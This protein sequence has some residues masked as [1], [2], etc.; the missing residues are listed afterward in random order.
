MAWLI[1]QTV[2]I[3]R[4]DRAGDKQQAIRPLAYPG[5]ENAHRWEVKVLDNGIPVSIAGYSVSAEFD[6]QDGSRAASVTSGVTENVAWVLFP[7]DVYNIEGMVNARMSIS[8]SGETATIAAISFRVSH[9]NNGPIIDPHGAITMDVA[10]LIADIEDATASIPADY[11][12]LL[13]TIAKNYTDLTFPISA[14]TF[15]WYDGEL[16]QAIDDIPLAE[17][18]TASHW[19]DG[20]LGP[21]IN[22]AL[23]RRASKQI[24]GST[25][26]KDLNHYLDFPGW[27]G[28]SYDASGSLVHGPADLPANAS[29]AVINF[30]NAM[31]Y[32]A[33]IQYMI[34]ELASWQRIIYVDSGA[35]AM[36][37]TRTVDRTDI[38]GIFNIMWQY[39]RPLSKNVLRDLN[40][41]AGISSGVTCVDNGDESYTLTGTNTG[42]DFAYF[43]FGAITSI[44]DLFDAG[45]SYR[46]SIDAD[47][48]YFGFTWYDS[49]QS[50]YTHAM[51]THGFIMTV[52][53]NT[54]YVSMYLAVP[55]GKTVN[56]TVHPKLYVPIGE[57]TGAVRFDVAQ[58]LTDA[59]RE[60]AR[61]NI[62]L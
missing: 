24:S 16:Y 38:D 3:A 53:Q 9:R 2:D 45:A 56:R 51:Y 33:T 52:P 47:D 18:W 59:Q 15:C 13:S 35:E 36:P 58:T 7:A 27:F 32:G 8:K 10:Q 12:S 21:V 6:R 34:S 40:S 23:Q 37:W 30:S 41:P 29:A 31:Y 43:F 54:P 50:Y 46:G 4:G 17:T 62:G 42:T 5:N 49:E 11:S 48:V 26:D 55:A 57:A 28:I 20:C 25:T 22:S 19:S 44:D 1:K 61:A 14:G 60:Q 39:M